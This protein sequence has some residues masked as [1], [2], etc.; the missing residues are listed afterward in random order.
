M[1]S[2]NKDVATARKTPRPTFTEDCESAPSPLAISLACCAF[3]G[4]TLT[5]RRTSHQTTT[6]M[7]PDR[8]INA[9]V[10]NARPVV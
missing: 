5:V 2:A 8:N 1:R 7:R 4:V 3:H 6:A 9:Y 10:T